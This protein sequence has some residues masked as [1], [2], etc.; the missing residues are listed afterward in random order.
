MNI[1]RLAR[2]KHGI[3]LSGVGAALG[4]NRWN[5]KGTEIIYCAESRALAVAEILVHLPLHIMPSGYMLLEIHVPEKVA[6]QYVDQDKLPYGWNEYPHNTFT[7]NIGD[8]F[9]SKNEYAILKVPSAVIQGDSNYLLN[10]KHPDFQFVKII[11]HNDF[12]IDK[13]FFI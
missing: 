1:Y 3:V 2:K 4:G 6:I 12:V 8:T 13:R 5:S 11:K 9:I 7:Q 10:P